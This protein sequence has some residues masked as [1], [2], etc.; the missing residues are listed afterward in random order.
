MKGAGYGRGYRYVHD[1][2]GAR[3]EMPCLPERFRG[4]DY[5]HEGS[6]DAAGQADGAATALINGVESAQEEGSA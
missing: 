3:E 1:D 5:L 6:P 2:P 4:R